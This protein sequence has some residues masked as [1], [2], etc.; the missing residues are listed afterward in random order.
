MGLEIADS[1]SEGRADRTPAVDFSGVLT[2]TIESIRDDPAELRNAIYELA[3]IKLQ[4]VAR[5][6]QPPMTLLE[7]RRLMLDL[8]RAIERVETCLSGQDQIWLAKNSPPALLESARPYL[9]E[10][11]PRTGSLIIDPSPMFADDIARLAHGRREKKARK[12][13]PGWLLA[14]TGLILRGWAI[15][16]TT[17]LLFVLLDRQFELFG[18]RPEASIASLATSMRTE[19]ALA[20][21][22][23][24][25]KS[26]LGFEPPASY[27]VYAVSRGKLYELVALPGRVP[28]QRVFMSAAIKTPS[29][30]TL[31]NGP[32][33]FV[34]YR[35]D[36]AVSAA[37][38]VQVRV[39]ARVMRAMMFDAGRANT[40]AVEDQWTIRGNA[41]DL[42]VSPV[43]DNP[44]MLMIHPEQS[45]FELPAGRYGLV[46]KG[47][48]YDFTV[49]GPVTD[50]TQCL[51]RI[52]AANGAFY[53][54][55]RQ[56]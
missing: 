9:S 35:R 39:V 24:H 4:R 30:T 29:P 25:P 13:F 19:R 16:V 12:L 1:D 5:Q 49:A 53:S 22:L 23:E 7:E 56:P 10:L 26:S 41:Y 42:R 32:I 51:E 15:A 20:I 46:I 27:G 3:R 50:P 8:E 21:P 18:N 33:S 17:F 38:R 54:E 11:S 48:A 43:P 14:G 37:E 31:P 6:Q 44:E 34:V 55:C 45:E 2:R 47:Q 28:D 40:A 52:A 36:V